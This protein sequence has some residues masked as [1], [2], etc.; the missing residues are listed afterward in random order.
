MKRV[1]VRTRRLKQARIQLEAALH[2]LGAGEIL[3][4]ETERRKVESPPRQPLPSQNCP[5]ANRQKAV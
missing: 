5:P 4:S 2:L 3:T 1:E